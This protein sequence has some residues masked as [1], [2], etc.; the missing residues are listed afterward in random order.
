MSAP[1]TGPAARTSSRRLIRLLREVLVA[2]PHGPR[3]F[4]LAV[5]LSAAASGAT[6]ALMGT[7]GWLLSR[8][9]Q[10]PPI[11]YLQVA[12]VGV[13]FFGISRGVLRYLERLIGHDLA[14]RMQGGLRQQAYDALSRTTLLGRRRGDLLVRLVADVDAVLDM[15]V[16]VAVPLCSGSLV[17]I[18][19]T[20]ILAAFNAPSA[21]VI[22][23]SAVLAGLVMPLLARRI[24]RTAD[25]SI[26]P[27]R[28]RMGSDARQIA[29][30]ATDLAAY[31]ADQRAIATFLTSD[32]D[33]RA[34]ES[35][36]AL[37]RGVASAGQVLAAGLAVICALFLG[38]SA[39]AAGDLDAPLLA[40]LVLTPLALHEVF[41]SFNQAA[42]TLTRAAS[43]L[44]RVAEVLDAPPVGNGDR[45]D[46]AAGDAPG[47][48]LVGLD[49]G[50]PGRPPVVT[51]LTLSVGPGDRV[52]L[53][54][55]SGIGKTTVAATIMGLIPPMGGSVSASG[56]V[57]YLAQDAHIF[58]TSLAENVRIGDRAATD[59]QVSDALKRAGL[60]LPAERRVGESGATLSGGEAQ[61]V[62]LARLLVGRHDVL[63]LDEPTE[64]LDSETAEALMKDFWKVAQDTPVLVI[65]HDE[66]VIAGCDR[67]ITLG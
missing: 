38:G 52:A 57:G 27:A 32:A 6:I 58:A 4:A 44:T 42:Q 49:A 9:A 7:S 13:R 62:A 36:A 60:D 8:A 46:L 40:V 1:T 31:G 5:L 12:V 55:P 37:A 19:S 59:E 10:H 30:A 45:V 65:S 67:I 51:G 3:R 63:V 2:V 35:R 23:G 64:Q 56:R 43:S 14:L 54:G 39:V 50:W 66:Q 24:S 17:I 21:L 20:A 16:R 48:Q 18:G 41:S 34:A 11:L 28:G 47:L 22:L 29:R 15:V 25:S 33:L 61:R 26:A 53:V